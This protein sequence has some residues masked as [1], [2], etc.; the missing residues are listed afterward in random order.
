MSNATEDHAIF[1]L[2]LKSDFEWHNRNFAFNIYSFILQ[3]CHSK[4]HFTVENKIVWYSV[5][6]LFLDKFTD[7]I[8]EIIF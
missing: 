6:L 3:L 4:S 8:R 5:A 1:F 7:V 2:F